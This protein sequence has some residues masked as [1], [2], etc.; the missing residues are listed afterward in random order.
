MS[1]N[2]EFAI[3]IRGK[4]G[5]GDPFADVDH[6]RKHVLEPETLTVKLNI[7]KSLQVTLC[8]VMSPS[9]LIIKLICFTL[10]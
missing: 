7:L 2:L 10:F 4:R 5:M 6:N 8:R 3:E 1:R 9:S